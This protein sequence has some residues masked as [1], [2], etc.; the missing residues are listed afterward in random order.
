[1][2]VDIYHGQIAPEQYIRPQLRDVSHEINPI[3]VFDYQRYLWQIFSLSCSY[4]KEKNDQIVHSAAS[5][6][7]QRLGIPLMEIISMLDTIQRISHTVRMAY[8]DSNITYR[9]DI[10]PDDSSH[11]MMR[12]WQGNGS[13]PQIWSIIISVVFSAL[14]SQGFGVHFSN[15]F[16]TEIS[17]LVG[18]SYVDNFGMVQS[19]NDVEVT[20]SQMQLAIPEWEDLIPCSVK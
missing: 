4:L 9:G 8:G 11:F 19:H 20:H 12:L 3:L 13:T 10:I 15:S 14:Q 17:Q 16:T 6:A 18:F 5:L 2:R 1:M 7:L